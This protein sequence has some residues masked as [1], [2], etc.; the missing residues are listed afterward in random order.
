[1]KAD[2]FEY[3]YYPDGTCTMHDCDQPGVVLAYD[4]FSPEVGHWFCARH[5]PN[6]EEICIVVED[7]RAKD[8]EQCK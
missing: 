1:M 4:S 6:F 2:E 7:K 8:G 5:W 3:I